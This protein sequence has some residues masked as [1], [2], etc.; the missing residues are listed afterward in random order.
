MSQNLWIMPVISFFKPHP[1]MALISSSGCCTSTEIL[2]FEPLVAAF[3]LLCSGRLQN[4]KFHG[5]IYRL[6][7]CFIWYFKDQEKMV[8][9]STGLVG[10][11]SFIA[12]LLLV[13]VLLL[14]TCDEGIATKRTAHAGFAPKGDI[15]WLLKNLVYMTGLGETF[16]YE[17]MLHIT[18]NFSE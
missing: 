1:F 14:R 9:H 6:V 18:G 4:G 11:I 2:V 13:M 10:G 15:S 8:V 16:T 17:Q 12:L 7:Y 5:R 3:S